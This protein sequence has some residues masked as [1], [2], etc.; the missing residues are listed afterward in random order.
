MPNT[1][2]GYVTRYFRGVQ[3]R[4]SLLDCGRRLRDRPM[5]ARQWRQ[6]VP[7]LHVPYP[8]VARPMGR[9]SAPQADHHHSEQARRA[10]VISAPRLIFVFAARPQRA[11]TP[12]LFGD[13][14]LPA[15]RA[16]G[17]CGRV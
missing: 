15:A 13:I 16:S 11:E 6:E 5:Q 3:A 2:I 7:H 14:V 4:A 1:L 9:I 8:W 10:R 17:Q 12:L